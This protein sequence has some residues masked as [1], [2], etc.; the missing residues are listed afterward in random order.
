M[1][2]VVITVSDSCHEGRRQDSSG[3]AVTQFLKSK[4][5]EVTGARILPDDE[6]QILSALE[7]ATGADVILTTGGTG[8]AQRDVTPEA[9]RRAITREIPGMAELMRA[10]GLR[11]TRRS[12]LS[13]GVVGLR[14]TILVVNLPGSPKGAVESL[15][16]VFDLLEHVVHLARGEGSDH[17]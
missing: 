12:V 1:K 11:K 6:A 10:E 14:G 16:A 17:G 3:P 13:R 2:C 8:V 7:Q 15:E 4:G 9:T 5:W